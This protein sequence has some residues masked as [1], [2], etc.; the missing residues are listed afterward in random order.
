MQSGTD[1][2]PLN[3]RK[4]DMCTPR[5]FNRDRLVQPGRFALTIECADDLTNDE[6]I[7]LEAALEAKVCLLQKHR[8][9]YTAEHVEALQAPHG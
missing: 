7:R 1:A 5:Q 8:R 6:I 9:G 3:E 4:A 2:Q